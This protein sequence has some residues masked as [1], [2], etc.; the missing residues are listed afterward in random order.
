[1]SFKVLISLDEGI[2]LDLSEG[3]FHEL[4]G[5]D[6]K[7][8]NQTEYGSKLPNITNSVDSICVHCDIISDSRVGAEAGNIIY[9]FNTANLTRSYPFKEEPMH[10]AY[11]NVNRNTIDKIR[12]YI[13]DIRNRIIDLNG[14]DTVFTFTLKEL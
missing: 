8:V 5:F 9:V 2:E 7:I 1:M 4:I 13:T 10:V 6:P 14:I 11:C 3:K 12:V